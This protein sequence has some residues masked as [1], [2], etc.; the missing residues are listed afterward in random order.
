MRYLKFAAISVLVFCWVAFPISAFAGTKAPDI[1]G[2]WTGTN[3]GVIAGH[4]PHTERNKRGNVRLFNLQ[5]TLKI[6]LQDGC[7]F[8]GTKISPKYSEKIVG[9]ISIDNKT[10]YMVD[11][12]GY[13]FGKLL[14]STKMEV[15]YMHTTRYGIVAARTVYTKKK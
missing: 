2:V 6:D 8:S 4:T 15:Y 3:E 1:C 13:F 11:E 5:L 9:V 7:R 12:D 10:F 14:S